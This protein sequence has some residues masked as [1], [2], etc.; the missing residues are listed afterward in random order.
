MTLIKFVNR[1]KKL[2]KRNSTYLWYSFTNLLQESIGNV[3]PSALLRSVRTHYISIHIFKAEVAAEDGLESRT[4]LR[5]WR[6]DGGIRGLLT[7][8]AGRGGAKRA[9]DFFISGK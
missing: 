9:L 8:G 1:R 3:I 7:P 6:H 2:K 5:Q 4:C